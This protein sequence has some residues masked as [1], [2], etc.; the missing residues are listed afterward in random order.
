ML[1]Q[2]FVSLVILGS[3][4]FTQDDVQELHNA[5]PW[6]LSPWASSGSPACI[7]RATVLSGRPPLLGLLVIIKLELR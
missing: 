5:D 3:A 7:T 1:Y 2:G 6:L 4:T